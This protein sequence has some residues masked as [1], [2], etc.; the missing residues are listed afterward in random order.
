MKSFK[1]LIRAALAALVLLGAANAAHAQI[2]TTDI[3]AAAQRALA[4][5][6]AIQQL[7]QMKAQVQSLTGNWNVG[8]VLN[9]PALHSYLPDQWESI[10]NKAKSGSL[11]GISSATLQI[12]QQEGL[13][14]GATSGQQRLNST[15]ATN[16]A[17]AQ[18]SYDQTIARLQN[19]QS[20]MQQSNLAQTAAEKQDLNNRLQAELAMVQNEQTRLNMMTSL[21]NAEVQ[22]AQRQAHIANKNALLGLDANGNLL[23]SSSRQG[24]GIPTDIC[25]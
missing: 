21:Q 12:M 5:D 11:N 17:M 3:A 18:A 7:T 8:V 9:D 19:I 22:L 23:P 14:N 20:L 13:T 1:S 2:P 10:Y 25:N 16:K 6:N 4:I 24:C 15:L